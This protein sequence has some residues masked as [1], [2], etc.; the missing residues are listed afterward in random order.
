MVNNLVSI[1]L[2]HTISL[3][4]QMDCNIILLSPDKNLSK[5]YRSE[6]LIQIVDSGDSLTS[7]VQ[8]VLSAPELKHIN[9]FYLIMPDIPELTSKILT[10]LIQNS[11]HFDNFL[12]P[13]TDKGIAFLKL[14]RENL[15]LVKFG[16]NSSLQ[17][18]QITEVNLDESFV[19]N[20]LDTEND[21]NQLKTS[22]LFSQTVYKT[23]FSS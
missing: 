6:R 15:R 12:V 13:T 17:F 11:K 22:E 20:D 9:N 5:R 8:Q 18:Q 10:K 7:A 16:Q 2:D 19:L 3:L 14:S 23:L 21:W 4:N 1:M